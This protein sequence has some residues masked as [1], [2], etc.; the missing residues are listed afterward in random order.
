M[1]ADFNRIIY[2][3]QVCDYG[4]ITKAAEHLYISPQALNKQMRVLEEE[5]GAKLFQRT[6][7]A[8]TLTSF[9]IF[10]RNQM[11]PVY[12]FYQ[13]AQTQVTHY[14]NATK[15]T[16]RV[17]FFQGVPK[18]QIIQPVITE[19]MVGLPQVQIELGSA[20]MDEIYADLR[21]GKIDLAITNVNPVDSLD[22]LVQ[23]PL[24]TMP[25]SI[26]VSYLHSWMVKESVDID[27]MSNAPVLFLARANGPDR[28]GFYSGLKASDYHFAPDYNTML[29]QLSL[30]QH[31]AVF[32]TVFENLEEMGLK[33]FPLPKELQAE[34]R[35]SLLYR[36]DNQ[37]AD[38]FSTLT[39]MQ[40]EFQQF[41]SPDSLKN[42]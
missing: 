20:E 10:F 42:P 11:K 4:S 6:S 8:L 31:Y 24:M 15:H 7:R 17:G 19:L 22:D 41:S 28:E 33:T 2:F 30:G 40:D 27:D 5:L 23:I 36:P 1:A 16:L 38:F 39:S 9:G 29:A 35:L 12:Q 32:P 37:F 34:F 13:A 25:C 26:V 14:L 3:L 18:R 21:S